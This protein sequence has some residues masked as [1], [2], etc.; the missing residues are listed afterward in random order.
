MSIGNDL[1]ELTISPDSYPVLVP[2]KSEVK[3]NAEILV[4][5]LL[6]R[7]AAKEAYV[8]VYARI[9]VEK[10]ALESLRD[11]AVLGLD[12]KGESIFGA[13]IMTRNKPAE[14]IYSDPKLE[15]LRVELDNIKQS[16]KEREKFNQFIPAEGTA[17][18]ET[19]L[20][21]PRP[22]K[23]EQGVTLAVKLA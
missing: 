16:I 9:E 7:M 3:P 15:R 19:G 2:K 13:T 14:W 1:P 18:P 21:I 5:S 10:E 12:G 22:T 4:A 20:I 11:R 17:D 8:L 23:N 6:D